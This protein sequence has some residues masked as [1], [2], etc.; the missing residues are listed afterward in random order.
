MYTTG[1]VL[2]LVWF[3]ILGISLFVT[4]RVL[5]L[6][7][8][9]LW[10][11]IR[12]EEEIKYDAHFNP[13]KFRLHVVYIVMLF[14]PFWFYNYFISLTKLRDAV[15]FLVCGSLYVSLIT[16]VVLKK[17]KEPTKK[18]SSEN[19]NQKNELTEKIIELNSSSSTIDEI[20]KDT[21]IVNIDNKNI[22]PLLNVEQIKNKIIDLENSYNLRFDK[23]ILSK[24]LKREKVGTKLLFCDNNDEI[25]NFK[26]I[27]FLKILD[28]IVDY[29]ISNHKKN[30]T[31]IT[32][33]ETNFDTRNLKTEKIISK[34]ISDL[35]YEYKKEFKGRLSNSM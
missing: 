14:Y 6:P 3:L 8:V 22:V 27:D 9:K 4:G 7:F 13:Y 24:I 25:A 31:S 5:Y 34:D 21:D 20:K 23:E 29:G 10:N 35:K 16:W 30:K 2:V 11:F 1:Y 32:W 17:I 19:S 33:I 12:D 15:A 28:N 18:W 26:K